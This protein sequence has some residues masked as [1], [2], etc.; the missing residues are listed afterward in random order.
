MQRINRTAYVLAA[1]MAAALAAMPPASFAAA[2]K[3]AHAVKKPKQKFVI[4]VSEADPKKWNLALNNAANAQEDLGKDQVLI[5]IVAYGPGLDML[6]LESEAGERVAAAL[7][8]G[9][10][11]VACQNT[12]RKQKLTEADMLPNVS[13]AKSGVVELVMKQS[14]GYAYIRP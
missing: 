2:G 3:P 10:K 14:E 1:A 9:I 6:K 13:Y 12:M 8:S 7:Q 11:V 5:E 4:Q